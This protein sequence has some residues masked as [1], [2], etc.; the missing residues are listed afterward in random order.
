MQG[1]PGGVAAEQVVHAVSDCSGVVDQVRAGQPVQQAARSLDSRAG[2]G[3]SR[4]GIDVEARVQ[5]EQPERCGGVGAQVPARPGEH[6]PDRGARVAVGV[7]QV[8][9]LLEA[10]QFCGQ[11]VQGDGRAGDGQLGGYPQRQ[12]QPRALVCQG[13]GRGRVGAGSRADQCPQQRDRVIREEQVQVQ[14][15]G[16]VPGHQARE[17]VAAGHDHHAVRAAGQQEADLLDLASVSDILC[18]G[19][20]VLG[21][22]CLSGTF[23][24]RY[25]MSLC[26]FLFS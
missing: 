11:V 21:T 18:A 16:A 1:L 13:R 7:Q 14:A 9:P 2:E 24:S 22:G 6:G 26:P 10:G 17:G 20:F 8:E 5:A 19:F 25:L 3:G 4:V 23:S 12:R 15:G